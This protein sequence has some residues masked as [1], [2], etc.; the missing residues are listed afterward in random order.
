MSRSIKK[1]T[2]KRKIPSKERNAT[3]RK[4]EKQRKNEPKRK[5]EKEKIQRKETSKKKKKNPKERNETVRKKEKTNEKR[6]NE[7]KKK[8]VHCTIQGKGPREKITKKTPSRDT[9]RGFSDISPICR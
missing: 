3:I 9:G 6:K 2:K 8:L 4:K 7:K 5:N 1:K